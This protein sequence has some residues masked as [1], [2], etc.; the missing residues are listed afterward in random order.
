MV[1]VSIILIILVVIFYYKEKFIK[2]I[3]RV[4]D[5]L[6]TENG[7]NFIRLFSLE[8][9][10][11]LIFAFYWLLKKEYTNKD[12]IDFSTKHESYSVIIICFNIF[13]FKHE[14]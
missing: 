13:I 4:D 6:K 3:K 12:I 1:T 2:L 14:K 5:Y 7:Y 8:I 11:F 10:I 9:I